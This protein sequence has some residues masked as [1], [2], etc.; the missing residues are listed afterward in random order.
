MTS[1]GNHTL[2]GQLQDIGQ[3]ESPVTTGKARILI[4]EDDTPVAMMMVYLLN[5]AGCE[6]EVAGTGKKAMQMA[7][8]GNF[9][10]ITLDVDL[11]DGNGFKLC[12]RLK[13]HPRLRDTPVLIVSGRSCLEDQQHG[14][15]LGA[16][17]YITKPFGLEFA[18]RLLSHIKAASDSV[19]VTKN[20]VI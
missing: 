9:D 19:A 4:V 12:S 5:R 1:T 8:A 10:L 18:P 11:P 15:E 6:T 14:L 7:E 13:G 3:A 20:I 2:L 16:V 17:D